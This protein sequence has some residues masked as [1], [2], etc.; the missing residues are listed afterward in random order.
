MQSG[1]LHSQPNGPML[2]PVESGN[3]QFFMSEQAEQNRLSLLD[4]W[5]II[6]RYKWSILAMGMIA[7][8]VGTFHAL[9]AT[10]IY[11]AHARLWVTVN[12]PNVS[13]GKQFE[14]APLYWLYFQTQSEIIRSRAV[15]EMVVERLGLGT[16]ATRSR[17]AR[18]EMTSPIRAIHLVREFAIPWPN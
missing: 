2:T 16:T 1:K 5:R 11:Q 12:Q 13:V 15:T 8:V 18:H 17:P 9:S 14:A 10:S 4:Y 7:G 6:R 3:E